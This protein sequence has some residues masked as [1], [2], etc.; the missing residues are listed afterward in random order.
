MIK[1][2]D[3]FAD[4]HLRSRICK[5]D[6]LFW[7]DFPGVE[8]FR[9]SHFVM[10]TEC[11][12]DEFIFV[13]ATARVYLYQGLTI[14]RTQ[15][16]TLFLAQGTCGIFPKDTILDFK[17][18]GRFKVQDLAKLL[19]TKLKIEGRMEEAIIKQIETT[20]KESKTISPNDINLILNSR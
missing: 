7:Q 15:T 6:V 1:I 18:L 16:D 19:G 13:R 12:N 20:V 11:L 8:R 17:M 9:D 3:T 2:P 4:Q 10:L 14:K 5:G